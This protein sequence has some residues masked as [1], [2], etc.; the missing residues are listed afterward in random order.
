[1]TRVLG[2]LA[3]PLL[4]AFFVGIAFGACLP[5]VSRWVERRTRWKAAAERRLERMRLRMRADTSQFEEALANA[6]R[7]GHNLGLPGSRTEPERRVAAAL[8]QASALAR[9]IGMRLVP[10][11]ERTH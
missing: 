4:A 11:R 1:M 2:W 9:S 5:W 8:E 3:L 10:D 6:A 7:A